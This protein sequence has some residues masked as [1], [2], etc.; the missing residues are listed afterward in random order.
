MW[1]E[2]IAAYLRP[3][4]TVDWPAHSRIA[5]EIDLG[6]MTFNHIPIGA[7][8]GI[9]RVFG[10]PENPKPFFR[11][12]F[13]YYKSGFQARCR[14]GRVESFEVFLD[15][16]IL[17]R[18]RFDPAS[19][20]IGIP[21]VGT[22]DL[23]SQAVRHNII[24]LLGEPSHVRQIQETVLLQYALG[25]QCLEFL[26]ASDGKLRLIRF[27]RNQTGCTENDSQR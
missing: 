1:V 8:A 6:A 2:K 22:A 4:P 18:C 19:V 3:D 10:R 24:Q 21:D 11:E 27:A 15:P 5:V 13:S 14:A 20:T 23:P 16:S 26:C 7:D 9:L 25:K 12:T 17:P